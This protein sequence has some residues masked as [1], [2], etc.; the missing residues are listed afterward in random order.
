MM[1]KDKISSEKDL[2]KNIV[3]KKK[4]QIKFVE[5]EQTDPLD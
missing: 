1:L 2:F 4:I 5:F 3:L